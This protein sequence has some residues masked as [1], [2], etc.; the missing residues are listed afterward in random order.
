MNSYPMR[1][2]Y[3]IARCATLY[4]D[5]RMEPYGL[6]GCQ[7]P[8]LPEIC[9]SPG[10]TQDQLAQILHVNRSSVTR[11]LALLEENGFIIRRRSTADRRA[12]EVYPTDKAQELLPVIRQV[13]Q[14]W[15]EKLFQDLEPEQQMLLEQLLDQL[16][17]RAEEIQ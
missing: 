13:R 17:K 2:I 11:Q 15:R 8:Y 9:R 10:I 6:T 3:T 12:V 1:S 16:A 7:L 5:K 4:R 14:S